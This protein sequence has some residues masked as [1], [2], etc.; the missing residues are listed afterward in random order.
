MPR[1]V[2]LSFGAFVAALVGAGL[3]L[4]LRSALRLSGLLER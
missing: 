4:S 3:A 1:P 2:R